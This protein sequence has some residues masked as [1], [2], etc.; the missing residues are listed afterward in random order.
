[1]SEL[2]LRITT[3]GNL[4]EHNTVSRTIPQDNRNKTDG[5]PVSL[6]IPD[7]QRPYKWKVKNAIRLLDD[8]EEARRSN[9]E[10]YR[11]GTL[12][13]HKEEIKSKNGK[14]ENGQN[15]GSKIY[16][17]N[18]VDGQQRVITFS[19]LLKCLLEKAETKDETKPPF[20]FLE[21]SLK[22]NPYNKWNVYQ[23]YQ[24]FKRRISSL[25]EGAKTDLREY[26]EKNCELVVI[27]TDDI[28]EAFQFFDSQNTRGKKLY[29]HDLL[30]AYHLR[31]MR[32][33][34]KDEIEQSVEEWESIDQT[35]LSKLFDNL[36]QLKEWI[37][38]N[39]PDEKLHERN[40]DLF[41]GVASQ[42]DYPYASFYKS[43]YAYI[44]TAN[45]S[46]SPFVTGTRKMNYFQIDAPVIAGR[47]FFK[48]TKHY[49]DL[50]S[51]IR[52]NRKY[53]G[54]FVNDN[55]IVKV[56]EEHYNTRLGDER[57]RLIFD[58]A[59]LL[60]IDRFAHD[61]PTRSEIADLEIFIKYA[62]IWAYSLRL[63]IFG[64]SWSSVQNYI[65]GNGIPS[66]KIESNSFNLYKLIVGTDT[67]K[68]LFNKLSERLTPVKKQY[69]EHRY[70]EESENQAEANKDSVT[71]LD[72]FRELLY[73]D[74]ETKKQS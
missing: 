40:I 13:L 59:I 18:I 16:E 54:C 32:N 8:I 7:Y 41:K 29:P 45:S 74:E 38:G 11:V 46:Y 69:I 64:V 3:I 42:D 17:Y 52:D 50:L 21:Q 73:L 34:T 51:D 23:N 31:E 20:K 57:A 24:A 72:L 39:R 28:S 43:A 60:Y 62:F 30:K 14:D 58:V 53:E 48:Y 66:K 33:C 49:Y 9:K 10:V 71:L 56:L 22:D 26:I 12:I 19:L 55:K 47:P 44:D 4:L 5:I 65:F 27:I 37:K 25:K 61:Y 35:D 1:M 68:D 63:C 15:K 2:T 67:P 6:K 70:V 36:Y